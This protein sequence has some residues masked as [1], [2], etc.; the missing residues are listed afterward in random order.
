VVVAVSPHH[1]ALLLRLLASLP[2]L[3]LEILLLRLELELPAPLRVPQ[4]VS[5][6]SVK[7]LP[8]LKLAEVVVEA[9]DYPNYLAILVPLFLLEL[10]FPL[11]L[12]LPC[13][14]L[15]FLLTFP[16][17]ETIH[18]LWFLSLLPL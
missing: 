15:S 13:L 17:A 7:P 8:V 6:P 11:P 18:R 2:V 14:I 5:L 4:P 10:Y 12:V 16:P 1:L 3:L 9:F